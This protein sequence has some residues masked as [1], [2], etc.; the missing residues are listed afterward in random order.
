SQGP[1]HASF[2][3]SKDGEEIGLFDPAGNL[4]D[5]RQFGPQLTDV[6]FGRLAG[7]TGWF[8]LLDP[9]PGR[10]NRPAPC[11][12]IPYAGAGLLRP[13]FSLRGEGTVMPSERMTLR[14][15]DAAPNSALGFAIG[16]EPA[17]MDIAMLGTVLVTPAFVLPGVADAEGKATF[18]LPLPNNPALRDLTIYTQALAVSGTTGA[19][20]AAVASRVCP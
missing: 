18:V 2:K 17:S 6:A 8:A 14:L 5:G 19:L 16:L 15:A 4:I 20:S 11:G 10:P 3:L 7:G 13:G 1:L 12:H 9:T